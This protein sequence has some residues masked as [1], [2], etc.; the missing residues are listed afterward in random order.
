MPKML[1]CFDILVCVLCPAE[2]KDFAS[3]STDWNKQIQDLEVQM[4]QMGLGMAHHVAER[5]LAAYYFRVRGAV[6]AEA[7]PSQ[8]GTGLMNVQLFNDK[9]NDEFLDLDF[10]SRVKFTFAHDGSWK[11][12]ELPMSWD[13]DASVS[14]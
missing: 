1:H 12:I 11:E 2:L 8:F 4:T 7:G 10:E 14:E 5:I 13:S 9:R 3:R 6:F